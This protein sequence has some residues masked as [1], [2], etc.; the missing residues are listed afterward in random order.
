[1]RPIVAGVIGRP[2]DI[3]IHVGCDPV[4]KTGQERIV[5]ANVFGTRIEPDRWRRG[6]Q[7]SGEKRSSILLDILRAQA[8]ANL[9]FKTTMTREPCT[10]DGCEAVALR[11]E[12]TSV[13][14][15]KQS[16]FLMLVHSLN[17]QAHA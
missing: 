1:L 14:E 15:L 3:E 9:I 12:L 5:W 16:E 4:A 7:A 8:R 2:E 17:R 6:I 13:C 11:G 10:R